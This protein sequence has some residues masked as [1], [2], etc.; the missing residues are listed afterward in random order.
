MTEI[1]SVDY[2]RQH[3]FDQMAKEEQFQ[4]PICKEEPFVA[5]IKNEDGFLPALDTGSETWKFMVNYLN[6]A[7]AKLR[8]K[9][10]S[11][12]SDMKTAQLRGKIRLAKEI[13][14]LPNQKG[15]TERHSN[16]SHL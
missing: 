16:N 14:D 13:L 4:G 11:D 10:D 7:I 15:L 3:V 12:I 9:N 5:K 8:E 6:L 1:N 2:T